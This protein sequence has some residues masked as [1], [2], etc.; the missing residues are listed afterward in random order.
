MVLLSFLGGTFSQSDVFGLF[1]QQKRCYGLKIVVVVF[2]S[3][4]PGYSPSFISLPL[5]G[6][7]LYSKSV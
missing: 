4:V 7:S 1:L 5:E 6:A 2:E 3:F